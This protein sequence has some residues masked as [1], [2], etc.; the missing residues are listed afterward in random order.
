MSD[1][2]P[3]G[4]P[5]R[6]MA[7]AKAG[8][9]LEVEGLVREAIAGELARLRALLDLADI[10]ADVRAGVV[11]HKGCVLYCALGTTPKAVPVVRR[12][13]RPRESP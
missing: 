7:A 11:S 9:A 13:K 5:G 8:R 4:L 2:L 12:K 3:P 10:T 1:E 6:I